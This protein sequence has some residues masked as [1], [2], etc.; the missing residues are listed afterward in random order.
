MT[1]RV[2]N[3]INLIE[4]QKMGKDVSPSEGQIMLQHFDSVDGM[5]DALMERIMHI[6]E[7]QINEPVQIKIA[8]DDDKIESTKTGVDYFCTHVKC[9][10]KQIHRSDLNF[11]IELLNTNTKETIILKY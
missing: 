9:V 2:V 6:Q 8:I 3:H 11:E 1:N 10:Y 7:N 4:F 5:T